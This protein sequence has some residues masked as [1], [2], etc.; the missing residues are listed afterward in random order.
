L[1]KAC[2]FLLFRYA[3]ETLHLNRV[4]LKTDLL[5]QQS[6]KAM[7]KV[8]LKQEGI[9]RKYQLTDSGRIRDTVFFS[10]INDEWND[11]KNNVFKEFL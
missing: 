3:F 11:I 6:Q 7:K 2:K 8:G 10:I 5:N 4:E 9:F 1:N